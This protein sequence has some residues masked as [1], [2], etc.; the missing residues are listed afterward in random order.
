MLL[1]FSNGAADNDA[2]AVGGGR[3][4]DGVFISHY[5]LMNA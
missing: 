1:L 3:S 2:A 5:S 4:G